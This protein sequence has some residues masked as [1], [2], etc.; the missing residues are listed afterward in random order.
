MTALQ[1]AV[2]EALDSARNYNAWV[3]SLAMP[4]LGDDPIEIGSGTGT[5]AAVWLEAGLPKL[6]VSEVDANLIDGLNERFAGEARVSVKELNLLEAVTEE[7][8]CAVAL[9]VLE[10]I[11]DDVAALRAAARLVSPEGAIV[12][13]VPAFPFAMSRFDRAI[14][15]YR[16]YT[17]KT[18]REAFVAARLTVEEL[19]Y[20]NAPGL[21]AWTIGMRFLRLTP[22]E[23]LVLRTWDRAVIPPTR[24][25]EDRW[26]PPFGQSLLIAGSRAD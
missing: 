17:A 2:L 22:R 6:T 11:A 7:H 16:R 13:F 12:M 3:A 20:V 4:Y 1:H 23:G 18:A 5:F 21:V 14:G 24:M 15:H 19:R 25:L 26:S 8:S 9:N 10:H